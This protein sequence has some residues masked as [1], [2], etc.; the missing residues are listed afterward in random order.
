MC[1]MNAK[2]K[3][4]IQRMDGIIKNITFLYGSEAIILQNSKFD[5]KFDY[6]FREALGE[7]NRQFMVLRKD[8]QTMTN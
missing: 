1:G 7:L 3:F 4:D 5:P 6:D 8:I 2:L